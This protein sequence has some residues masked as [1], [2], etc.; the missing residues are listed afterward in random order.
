[1][2]SDNYQDPQFYIFIRNWCNYLKNNSNKQKYNNYI[3]KWR[4][5]KLEMYS[6]LPYIPNSD[7][8]LNE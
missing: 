2:I 8:D 7:N 4:M 5:K 1:M 6:S 3:L